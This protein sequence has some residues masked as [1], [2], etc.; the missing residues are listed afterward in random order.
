MTKQ[1][2]IDPQFKFAT[3]S[4]LS[5]REIDVRGLWSIQS[6]A[7]YNLDSF[8][9]AGFNQTLA[10]GAMLKTDGLRLIRLWPQAAYLLSDDYALPDSITHFDSMI[11]DISHG[12]IELIL[13]GGNAPAFI[14]DYCSADISQPAIVN[15]GTLRTRLGQFDIL[16]W[17]DD[18]TDIRI[19]VDRSHAQSFVSYLQSL[20]SRWFD[21]K[22]VHN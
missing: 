9:K 19:L 1:P 3:E 16:L 7:T 20:S 5:L 14:N 6:N 17:W 15:A 18:I 12:F 22:I 13:S 11:T 10:F 4:D 21:S 2:L 8:S